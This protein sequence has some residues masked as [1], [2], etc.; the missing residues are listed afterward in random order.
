MRGV[1][2]RYQVRAPASLGR[3]AVRR[4][5][6]SRAKTGET[7]QRTSRLATPLL[8]PRSALYREPMAPSSRLQ[9]TCL[10]LL[11][12][13]SAAAASQAHRLNDPLP[14]GSVQGYVRSFQV[15][16]DESRVVFLADPDVAGHV[17]LLS[18]ALAGPPDPTVLSAPDLDAVLAFQ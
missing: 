10:V 7:S 1:L 6:R 9:V 18:A 5:D 12:L 2:R 13:S 3:P 4:R 8:V 17:E 15:T 11:A 16:P 14:L